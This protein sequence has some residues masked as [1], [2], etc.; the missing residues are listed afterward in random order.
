MRGC[1]NGPHG[2]VEPDGKS[3]GLAHIGDFAFGSAQGIG[4]D[5]DGERRGL[6][7]P[8]DL[9]LGHNALIHGDLAV[10]GGGHETSAAAGHA[11]ILNPKSG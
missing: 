4:S 5:F 10:G 8:T 6:T 11:E 2:T 9:R 3:L 7:P 1:R